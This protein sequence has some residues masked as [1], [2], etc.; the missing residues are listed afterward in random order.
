MR[1]PPEYVVGDDLSWLDNVIERVSGE[2]VDSKT[3][4]T[5]LLQE[6]FTAVRACHATNTASVNPYY[7]KGLLLMNPETV[8]AQAR[9]FFLNGNFPKLTANAVDDAIAAVDYGQRSGQI[10]FE[11]NEAFLITI[12]GQYLIYGGEYLAAIAHN[13]PS[14]HGLEYRKAL[15]DLGKPTMFI[16]DVPWRDIKGNFMHEVA[17][18]ALSM[19]FQEL[20]DGDEY[21]PDPYRAAGFSIFRPL[22]PG[23]I[24]GH[25]H[26][27]SVRDPYR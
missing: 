14:N 19:L 21:E 17:G 12:C 4:M 16:C 23:N 27:E 9:A 11:S 22:D 8:H 7:Q 10:F 2:R 15:K 25:Y 13:L 3:K 5:C 24:V 1:T 6:H 18:Y 20:L 26:L